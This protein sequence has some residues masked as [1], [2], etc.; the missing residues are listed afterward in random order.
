MVRGGGD[1]CI[2]SL[3]TYI[4]IYFYLPIFYENKVPIVVGILMGGF[5]VVGI[6]V[7]GVVVC[8]ARVGVIYLLSIYIAIYFYLSIFNC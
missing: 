6:G 8:K 7:V 3:S 5:W 4:V 1:L 2:F